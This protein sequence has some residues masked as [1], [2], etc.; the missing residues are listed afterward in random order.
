MV[1]SGWRD[2]A[3]QR[4]STRRSLH[5]V[6]A[7]ALIIVFSGCDA[8]PEK[9]IVG[10]WKMQTDMENLD[11]SVEFKGDGGY[12]M[13][14]DSRGEV[15]SVQDDGFIHGRWHIEDNRIFGEVIESNLR[16]VV[17]GKSDPDE[18]IRLTPETLITRKPTG[19]FVTYT[20]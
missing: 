3:M 5:A 17:P 10:T 9:V 2:L 14:V 15:A 7:A 20:R 19:D 12:V 16:N 6:L 13:S 8:S 18:I 11:I 4:F 1:L